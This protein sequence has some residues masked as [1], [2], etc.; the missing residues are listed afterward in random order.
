MHQFPTL[1]AYL[2]SWYINIIM[3]AVEILDNIFFY[4][5]YSEIYRIRS[6]CKA[7]KQ[8][9]EYHLYLSVKAKKTKLYAKVGEKGRT[10]LV[11]MEP[12]QFDAENQVIEFKCQQ[13][14]DEDDNVVYLDSDTKHAKT[15]IQF[16]EWSSQELKAHNSSV[17]LDLN[18]VDCAQVLFHL[19]YNPSME[20]VHSLML[21]KDGQNELHYVGDKG[22]IITY[23]YNSTFEEQPGNAVR[24]YGID[25]PTTQSSSNSIF[26]QRG[27]AAANSTVCLR[28]HSIHANL[29]WL[30]SGF[31]TRIIPEPLYPKRY[32]IL[33]DTL[34]VHNLGDRHIYAYSESVL[35]CIMTMS[36]NDT[37]DPDALTQLLDQ[38]IQEISWKEALQ[39]KL[40]SLGIDPRVIYKYTFVKNY[41]LQQHPP[42]ARPDDVAKVIQESEEAWVIKKLNLMQQLRQ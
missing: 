38:P 11:D 28:I 8:Q 16:S 18:L 20:Q 17:L 37:V 6:V 22:I 7:W 42:T 24:F 32:Q 27:A 41:M 35:K 25:D 14:Q 31:H 13:P 23:S 21:P 39:A 26:D 5:A 2:S 15:Q 9:C 30:L 40:Q 4:L 12:H 33:A 10:A 34:S 1:F 19:Q 29:S 36:N 3:L